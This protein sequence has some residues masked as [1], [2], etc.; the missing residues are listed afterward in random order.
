MGQEKD[1]HHNEKRSSRIWKITVVAVVSLLALG[2]VSVGVL[3]TQHEPTYVPGVRVDTVDLGEVLPNEAAERLEAWWET[4]KET[5][6][7]L[8]S[9]YM[10][11]EFTSNLGELG[12]TLDVQ[13]TLDQLP[14]SDFWATISRRTQEAN[15]TMD[16]EPILDFSAVETEAV[17]EF[18]KARA[19]SPRPASIDYS[20]GK[21]VRKYEVNGWEA[22]AED[23]HAAILAAY[24]G[25]GTAE[26]MLR[27]APKRISDEDLDRID[28][29]LSEF[30]TT[31]NQGQ[32]NRSHN[33]KLASEIISGIVL[34]PGERMSFNK[35]VG[36]RTAGRG[37]KL[38]G[39]YVSGRRDVDIGGGICQVSTTL[40]NAALL[41]DM[42]IVSRACHSLPVPYVPLGR[43]AAVSY[44]S[45]DLVIENNR[46]VPVAIVSTYQS[47]RI[48]FKV[49][50]P[51]DEKVEVQIE[52]RT[53]G[54]WGHGERFV[55]DGTLAYG[56][57]KVVDQGGAGRRAEMVRRVLRDGNVVRTDPVVV[58]TYRGGPRI[59]ARNENAKPPTDQEAAA[60]KPASENRES[61]PAPSDNGSMDFDY[62]QN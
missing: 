26:V 53:T 22:R 40:Y 55:H 1:N 59:V 8:T 52:Q 61:I 32:A 49:L 12:V 31:F 19:H 25:E 3:Y 27:H 48:T 2:G 35:V 34:A 30:T 37:F 43:D 9:P 23:V 13:A 38:A 6:V 45:L 16:F 41:S 58:S 4:V 36:Q 39:V 17:I 60:A 21:I 51:K 50:G 28:T 44:P 46:D 11:G 47:G 57:T 7:V 56:V 62:E 29:V 15:P 5:E 14:M 18:V 20:T 33:I 24:H 10:T 54:S 42:K